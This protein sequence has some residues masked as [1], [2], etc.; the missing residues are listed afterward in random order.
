[1]GQILLVDG[2]RRE[3]E[4]EFSLRLGMFTAPA[5]LQSRQSFGWSLFHPI[6]APSTP[7]ITQP[8]TLGFPFR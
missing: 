7:N 5:M 8:L 1:M 6:L 3:I 4:V 2:E